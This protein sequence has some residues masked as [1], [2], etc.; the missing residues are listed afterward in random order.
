MDR[1]SQNIRT[2]T[3]KWPRG[4]PEPP[5]GLI[6]HPGTCS[7]HPGAIPEAS[8]ATEHRKTYAQMITCANII[9]KCKLKSSMC[10]S[11][12]P[13]GHPKELPGLSKRPARALPNP[14]R[15]FS[16][17]PRASDEPAATKQQSLDS[18][19]KHAKTSQRCPWI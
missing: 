10:C 16:K 17:L 5:M 1:C 12:S 9:G 8:N 14:P 15:G 3:S 18:S 7:G 6:G 19:H 13:V 11:A 2:R 4:C